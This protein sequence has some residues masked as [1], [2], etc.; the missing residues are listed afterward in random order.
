MV[1]ERGMQEREEKK[2]EKGGVDGGRRGGLSLPGDGAE[3]G[4]GKEEVK[5]SKTSINISVFSSGTHA[6][7]HQRNG[8]FRQTNI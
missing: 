1:T 7:T 3:G 6:G 2:R 4:G 8:T 5:L